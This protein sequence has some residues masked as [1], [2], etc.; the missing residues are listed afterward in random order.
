MEG[1]YYISLGVL[2]VLLFLYVFFASIDFG[3]AFFLLYAKK[4]LEN[5]KL[6]EYVKGFFSPLWGTSNMMFVFFIIGL[7][8]LYPAMA[9]YYSTAFF[10]PGCIA[11]LLFVIRAIYFVVIPKDQEQSLD[12]SWPYAV[13][14]MCIPVCLSTGLIISEGGFIQEDGSSVIFLWD[15]FFH[16]P[17]T[18]SV[19]L[20]V[21]V[22]ILYISSMFLCT[23]A[24]HIKDSVSFSY[25]RDFTL[26]WAILLMIVNTLVV[27]TLKL[28]NY[29]H[30]ERLMEYKI[31]IFLSICC[32]LWSVWLVFR[33]K[34]LYFAFL[35][36]SLY[37]LFAFV[38]YGI[39][40]LP[41]ILTPFVMFD[42]I[43]P[44]VQIVIAAIVIY[45]SGIILMVP[46]G[47]ILFK[48]LKGKAQTY[49][50]TSR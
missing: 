26:I 44:N 23:Y 21:I 11:I 34:Q 2:W 41:S 30:F 43:A 12:V 9:Y 3:V 1:Y 40:H 19:W 46:S 16:S 17:Y 33:K 38:A 25:I 50:R 37:L 13:I 10:L 47:I 32:Y 31:L 48:K 29:E 22:S 8:A 36:T 6:V 28:H 24:A 18:W 20:Y 5:V 45:L 35:L 4:R 27:Y 15:A 39:S 42:D 49:W 14:G 7:I